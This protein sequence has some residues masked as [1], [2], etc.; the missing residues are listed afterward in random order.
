MALADRERS[1]SPVRKAVYITNLPAN[2]N[3]KTAWKDWG[4]AGEL[5]SVKLNTGSQYS[6]CQLRYKTPEGAK[7]AVAW[8]GTQYQGRTCSVKFSKRG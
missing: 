3:Q 1:R 4:R 7:A 2:Y 6:T 5:E 8:N